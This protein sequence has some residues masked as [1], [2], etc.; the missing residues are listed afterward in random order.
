MK[1]IKKSQVFLFVV[2][3]LVIAVPSSLLAKSVEVP[4]YEMENYFYVCSNLQRSSFSITEESDMTHRWSTTGQPLIIADPSYLLVKFLKPTK[5]CYKVRQT[6]G[7][8]IPRQAQVKIKWRDISG[9]SF[10]G[11]KEEVNKVILQT[12]I[13][14]QIVFEGKYEE[15]KLTRVVIKERGSN[16]YLDSTAVGKSIKVSAQ[17]Y[18]Q[19]GQEMRPDRYEW[20]WNVPSNVVYSASSG[21]SAS[22]YLRID[23]DTNIS[24]K[25]EGSSVTVKAYYNKDK[26]VVSDAA[27]FWILPAPQSLGSADLKLEGK[28]P[29]E[30]S[31]KISE[32][33]SIPVSVAAYDKNERAIESGVSYSWKVRSSSSTVSATLS[34]TS[35]NVSDVSI[36]PSSSPKKATIT[37]TAYAE[38]VK[39]SSACSGSKKSKSA[40]IYYAPPAAISTNTNGTGSGSTN[41][42]TASNG[43]VTGNATINRVKIDGHSNGYI[44]PNT[45]SADSSSGDTKTLTMTALDTKGAV[46]DSNVSYQWNAV[47]E[48][49]NFDVMLS[50][51]DGQ[52]TTMTVKNKSSNTSGGYIK[53]W[54]K[55]TSSENSKTCELHLNVKP[56]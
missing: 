5:Y 36:S 39:N 11:Q 37:I 17:A 35:G 43:T 55:A 13:M 31:N 14:G 12:D 49:G 56:S 30:Y 16:T 8:N 19:F 9:Y 42:S 1:K 20:Q 15:R 22:S 50:K 3:C 51:Y 34:S 40:T 6:K 4:I 45:V 27:S 29:D 18:D 48:K 52:T 10:Y 23:K 41:G 32:G 46:I 26:E 28:N 38:C 44:Y 54:G 53:I 33:K 47:D 7:Y 21:K 24:N 25:I 2:F